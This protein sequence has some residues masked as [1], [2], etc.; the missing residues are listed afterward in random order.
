MEPWS[1]GV[2]FSLPSQGNSAPGFLLSKW[3]RKAMVSWNRMERPEEAAVK[4]DLDGQLVGSRI[5]QKTGR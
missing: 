4:V 5:T 3:Q 2:S 1:P